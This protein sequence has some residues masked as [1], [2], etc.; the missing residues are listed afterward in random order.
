MNYEKQID[1]FKKLLKGVDEY[2]SVNDNDLPK[3]FMSFLIQKAHEKLGIE[4]RFKEDNNFSSL[5]NEF[6]SETEELIKDSNLVD[7]L[8]ESIVP[9]K[10]RKIHG[11]FLTPPVVADFMV[12]WGIKNNCNSM[13][14]P[15][16]GTGI[17]ASKILN[18]Q[19]MVKNIVC[20]DTDI[21]MLNI[22][23]F[24]T[25]KKSREID[26]DLI[27][28]NFLK[29]K[30]NKKFGLVICNPPYMNFHDYD[31]NII[32][33]IEKMYNIKISKLTNIYSLFFIHSAS[34]LEENGRMVYITPS[35][36]LYTGYGIELKK[37]L[38][39]N[40]TINAFILTESK[41]IVFNDALTSSVVTLLENKR[42][43]DGHKVKFIK[44]DEW[45]IDT[46]EKIL[47]LLDNKKT[48][49]LLCKEI[50]QISLNPA[51][52]WLI[53]FEKKNRINTEKLIPLRDIDK[54][55][56][57]IATG[58]NAFFTLSEDEIE[59]WHIENKFL[60]PV[61][62]KAAHGKNYDFSKKDFEKL[63]NN[64]E[65]VFLLYVFSK[66]SENL[67]KYI[68]YGEELKVNKRYL[69]FNRDPW[70]SME[71]RKPAPILATVFSRN[72]MRF[73]Y[74]KTHVLNLASFHGIY[75]D[76]KDKSK[77]KA[78]LAY[79]NSNE[80]KKI[81][82]SEKRTYGGGLDKFEPRDLEEIMV[83]DINKLDVVTLKK[84]SNL[85]DKLCKANRDANIKLEGIVKI[86]I[87]RIIKEI[88]NSKLTDF[89]N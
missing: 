65:K 32:S 87:D 52:K 39:D 89:T 29:F 46:N 80:A 33:N 1:K 15:S 35:E 38:L 62:S 28:N 76:F 25:F 86:E 81:M 12:K 83:I 54:V 14:D 19:S 63:V 6:S 31:R 74:N 72:N 10:Y 45:N 68:K 78:L 60:K 66:P 51:K 50:P 55:K 42:C 13:L 27:N 53:L 73:I 71:K 20:I 3:L 7:N 57:G 21:L 44:V 23:N 64:K 5:S 49:G 59:N 85:F 75:P 34:F 24:R 69:A 43:E 8:Y 70:F 77:I 61:L 41:N 37:F 58:H 36:F 11:Q 79:L 88:V 30:E 56:R 17:F 9:K 4:L 22:T 82:F 47:H 67:K 48:D 18:E 2:A 84:L 40:F 16:V 26:I